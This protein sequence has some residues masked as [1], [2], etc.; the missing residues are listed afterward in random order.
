MKQTI[1]DNLKLFVNS[2]FFDLVLWLVT[3]QARTLHRLAANCG[4]S[5]VFSFSYFIFH[6]WWMAAC[7]RA[8]WVIERGKARLFF[9]WKKGPV[10]L[11]FWKRRHKF[12]SNF[13]E[14]VQNCCEARHE[15]VFLMENF[16]RSFAGRICRLYQK[17]YK[18]CYLPAPEQSWCLR[19]WSKCELARSI[20]R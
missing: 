16:W 10:T 9:S 19:S 2:N 6:D 14:A 13:F 1:C 8:T 20:T 17:S 15:N 12:Q 3:H 5:I 11:L 7:P 4:A 18:F